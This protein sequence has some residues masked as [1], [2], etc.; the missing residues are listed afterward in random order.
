MI[1]PVRCTNSRLTIYAHP[2]QLLQVPRAPLIIQWHVH[3]HDNPTFYARMTM[4]M[5]DNPP[6]SARSSNHDLTRALV[7]GVS[8]IW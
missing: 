3:H 4:R 8:F 6:S 5:H 7:Q 2:M 1:C